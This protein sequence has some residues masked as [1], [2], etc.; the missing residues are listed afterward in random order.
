[1][2]LVSTRRPDGGALP[3]H[4][5]CAKQSFA[6]WIF[7]SKFVFGPLAA[8]LA[9]G[10]ADRES[11]LA[12]N[13]LHIP[14]CGGTSVEASLAQAQ[15]SRVLENTTVCNDKPWARPALCQCW[16]DSVCLNLARVR[17][18]E[19]SHAE[20]VSNLVRRG[21]YNRPTFWIAVMRRPEDWFYSAVG[22]WCERSEQ[23]R[24]WPSLAC[25]SPANVSTLTRREGWFNPQRINPRVREYFHHAN[26]QTRMLG[27]LFLESG[28]L[29]CSLDRISHATLA[30]SRLLN[31]PFP[32]RRAT[33]LARRA[34][35]RRSPH[36]LSGPSPPRST[37]PQ[38]E[39]KPLHV[40]SPRPPAWPRCE[41]LPLAPKPQAPA[42]TSTPISSTPTP[43]SPR[44]RSRRGQDLVGVHVEQFLVLQYREQKIVLQD[45]KYIV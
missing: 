7:M 38:V 37:L 30:A 3:R 18:S 12:V 17:V 5:T 20:F 24:K 11:A 22:Q 32:L 14:K 28:W 36:R 43:L 1:M 21:A 42:P 8:L 26:L 40:S 39:H 31:L 35:A 16:A 45:S 23:Q 2:S 6:L 25:H 9:A 27:D 29:L 33:H 4:F 15:Q 19:K 34:R 41:T 13:W 44:S 10:A